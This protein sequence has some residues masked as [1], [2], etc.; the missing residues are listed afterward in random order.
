MS[1]ERLGAH[2]ESRRFKQFLERVESCKK[3][4][5][6]E[7]PMELAG[8]VVLGGFMKHEEFNWW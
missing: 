3:D 5:L 7:K 8:G 4:G 1:E 6:V 2:L